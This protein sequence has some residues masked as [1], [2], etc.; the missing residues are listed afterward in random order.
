[1][2]FLGGVAKYLFV[3]LAEAVVFA[4]IASYG[5]SRTLVPT[6]SMYLLRDHTY[7]SKTSR[8]PL[9]AFQKGFESLFAR[10]RN[11]YLSL[12]TVLV[13]RRVVFT[14][15]FLVVCLGTLGLTPLLGQ[16][17]FPSSDNGQMILH[18]RAK[19]GTR[20]EETARLV[21]LVDN[22]IRT[23]I[24]NKDL[25]NIADNIGL[26]YS[27]L[28]L[29]RATSGLVGAGDADIFVSLKEGHRPTVD[30]VRQLRRDLSQEFPGATFYFLPADMVSQI[31]NFGIPSPVDIQIDGADVEGNRKVADQI[32]SELRHV[33][34]IVDARVQQQFD[35]PDLNVSIDRTKAV[36]AGFTERDVAN[37][38]LNTLSGSFQITPMF[39]LNWENGVSYNLVAQTPQYDIQ[40]LHDL[41]NIPLSSV[42]VKAPEVL[43]DVASIDRSDEMEVVNHYN[44][45]RVVD[46]F[47]SVDGRDLGSVGRDITRIINANQHL[48]PHGSFITVRGQLTTMKSSY[49]ALLSGLAFS[50]ILVYLL[51]V[52][53]FQSWLDPFIIVTALTGALAGI[54]LLLFFSHTTLSVPALMGAIMCMGVAT[55]NS[56]LVVSFARDQLALHGDAVKAATEA[57]YSRLRPVIMTALAMV[58]G[59]VP[60]ALGMG[61]GGEQNAPL[62][63]AVIGGLV[64]ATVAT[65]I[66]V[67]AVFALCHGRRGASASVS[68]LENKKPK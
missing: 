54:V 9:S 63:R 20:I 24:P 18:L 22:F 43:A 35:Y 36:Q 33:P 53:N 55:A 21:D 17:F 41:R 57:G 60:M 48:L 34:G 10:F 42:N 56:I 64:V 6:L 51:I 28:N 47:A 8:N 25:D 68:S 11:S 65:L 7:S 40:S 26:P 49:V 1:M 2:F 66:F 4:M 23:K 44:V 16:D 58:I 13:R 59:M 38:L 30:Y 50:I 27:I 15:I 5:L 32:L 29:M 3:P 62:G 45:R 14:S 31:L 39:F 12:L 19:S 52:I 37:N 67:P 46:I 61:D